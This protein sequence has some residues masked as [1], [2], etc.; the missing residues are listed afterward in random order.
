[1]GAINSIDFQKYSKN[2][3]NDT[4]GVINKDNKENK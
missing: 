3:E 2:P 4:E 1:M